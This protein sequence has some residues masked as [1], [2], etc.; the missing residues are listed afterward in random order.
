M[1]FSQSRAQPGPAAWFLVLV[2]SMVLCSP[3]HQLFSGWHCDPGSQS[4]NGRHAELEISQR[5]PA[6]SICFGPPC[7]ARSRGPARRV[8]P[9]HVFYVTR[10]DWSAFN[11]STAA[12]PIR[13]FHLPGP[14]AT[15][16]A[17]CQLYPS[18]FVREMYWPRPPD[19]SWSSPHQWTTDRDVVEG[20]GSW[21]RR[22]AHPDAMRFTVHDACCSF[23][24]SCVT[25]RGCAAGTCSADEK[26]RLE[27]RV[28]TT[29]MAQCA[30]GRVSVD[31]RG[32]FLPGRGL[33]YLPCFRGSGVFQPISS[34][35]FRGA[36]PG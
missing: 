34:F 36:R 6:R 16:W 21:R 1:R 31:G 9:P 28:L 19:P 8:F 18:L 10:P 25:K 15:P 24:P 12:G 33:I 29:A 3:P 11:V 14:N 35:R 5:P 7:G 20:L 32:V 17:K 22:M 4:D 13:M 30:V 26:S 2:C 27:T 23:A